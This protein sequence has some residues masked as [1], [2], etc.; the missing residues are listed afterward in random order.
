MLKLIKENGFNNEDGVKVIKKA[1][2]MEDADPASR[3][4]MAAE[5]RAIYNRNYNALKNSP[6]KT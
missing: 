5:L 2:D 4:E 1:K 3:K 6:S